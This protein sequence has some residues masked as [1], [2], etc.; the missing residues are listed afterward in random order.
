MECLKCG[1]D[2]PLENVLFCPFCGA[3]QVKRQSDRRKKS[4]GNGQGSAYHRIVNG[5]P[6]ATW[7]ISVVVDWKPSEDGS[8]KIPVKRT[9]GGFK[10]KTE[11][12]EAVP[13]IKQAYEE[14]KK[15][16]E[17]E[18][19]RKAQGRA[20]GEGIIERPQTP[21]VLSYYWDT[22]KATR[23]KTLSPSKQTAYR[24]AWEK[25]LAS[26]AGVSVDALTVRV[27]QDTLDKYCE[28]YYRAKDVKNLLSNLFKL[29]AADGFVSKDIPSLLVLPE[30][31]EKEQTPFSDE[32]QK[33][34][35]KAYESG[36][37]SVCLP[38]LMIY[39]GMM[40][41][42]V[43]KLR[44]EQIDLERKI[45]TGAGLKT[46]ARKEIPVVIAD[47]IIPVVQDLIDNARDDGYLW[48]QSKDDWY[49]TY[50]HSLEV[51]G[52]R[53]LT[54]Y[55]CRHTTATALAVTENVAPQTVRRVMRWSTA[56]M[57]DRYAHPDTQD[58]LDAVNS[59]KK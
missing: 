16:K 28:S 24:I 59:I 55:S 14:E 5:K 26:V 37:K 54:P 40:P 38:L 13:R 57:L 45:I 46:K 41:G 15:R 48:I 1:K 20:P 39:S 27:L 23:F 3:S 44:V 10:T 11:A 49:D 50:Y 12:I 17:E 56:K 52:V 33:A 25:R 42:E 8:H 51:A 34:L 53:K 6:Q 7:T 31:E 32:E 2:I 58:A 19:K 35:W 22:Y 29:A 18:K 36:E 21:P 47:C 30:L 9:L 4:R 43:Q